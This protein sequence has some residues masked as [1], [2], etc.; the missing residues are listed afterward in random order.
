MA[1]LRVENIPDPRHE[2]VVLELKLL[3]HEGDDVW[4]GLRHNEV[5]DIEQFR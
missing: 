2:P 4:V 1:D 5:I 3:R